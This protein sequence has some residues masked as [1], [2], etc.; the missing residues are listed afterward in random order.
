[1]NYHKRAQA[2]KE[3]Y[4][5]IKKEKRKLSSLTPHIKKK[6]YNNTKTIERKKARMV[7]KYCNLNRLWRWNCKKTDWQRHEHCGDPDDDDDV[8]CAAQRGFEPQGIADGVPP[9]HRDGAE[10]EH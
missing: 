4:K 5:R 9:L 6:E 3:K 2:N 8:A 1:M 10:G 7:R